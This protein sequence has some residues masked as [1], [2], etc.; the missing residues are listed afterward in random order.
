VFGGLRLSDQE[1]THNLL[2]VLL[3][4]H[5]TSATTLTRCLSNL[6]DHP[7]VLQKLREEQQRVLT[8][9][10]PQ[11]TA[12]ALKDMTYADAVIRWGGGV[13]TLRL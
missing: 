12:A 7:R 8:K 2:L 10:G 4:G 3:A 6:Q 1:I 13:D 11:V 9:H 5:D